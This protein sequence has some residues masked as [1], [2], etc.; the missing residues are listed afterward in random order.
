[1]KLKKK[2]HPTFVGDIKPDKK[3]GK[4][5]MALRYDLIMPVIGG[6]IEEIKRQEIGDKKSGRIKLSENLGKLGDSLIEV[7]KDVNNIVKICL[8]YIKKEKQI[9]KRNQK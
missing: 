5:I 6:M 4:N 8:P 3:L 7:K 2:I 1:M 9:N